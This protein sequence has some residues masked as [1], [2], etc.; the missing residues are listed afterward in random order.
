MRALWAKSDGNKEDATLAATEHE[1]SVLAVKAE[2]AAMVAKVRLTLAETKGRLLKAAPD[3]T[4][5]VE[6]EIKKVREALENAIKTAEASVK[7]DESFTPLAGAQWTPARFFNSTTD[8]P[9]V[10][11]PAQSSGRRKALAEWIT[12]RR[13]PLTARV[14]VNHIWARH[15]GTPL[16]RTVFDFGRKGTPPA[17]PELLDWLAAEFMEGGWSEASAPAHCYRQPIACHRLWSRQKNAKRSITLFY[18][19]VFPFVSRPRLCGMRS[20]RSRETWT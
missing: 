4:E 2:R 7:P 9:V 5:S 8:D 11:F 13:N 20:W 15:L 17:D 16:V 19:D 18:G 12:D 6:N 10:K 14:A 1:K 3:K